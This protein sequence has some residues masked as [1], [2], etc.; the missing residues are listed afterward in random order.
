VRPGRLYIEIEMEGKDGKR[1]IE[2]RWISRD[3]TGDD[4]V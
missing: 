4:E 2:I 1:D 3:V